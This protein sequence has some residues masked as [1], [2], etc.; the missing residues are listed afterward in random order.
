MN[1]EAEGW[2]KRKKRGR[3]AAAALLAGG[4]AFWG[5]PGFAAERTEVKP[6]LPAFQPK[7]VPVKW[8]DIPAKG[9][10]LFYPGQSSWD[11]LVNPQKGFTHPGAPV[12]QAGVACRTCHVKGGAGPDE[13]ALGKKLVPKGPA[14]DKPIAGKRPTVDLAVRAAYDSQNMYFWLQWESEE[15]GA[16]HDVMRFDGKKWV[17]Y[18]GYKP[19]KSPG[20]YEDRLTLNIGYK[21]GSPGYV[22]AD[23]GVSPG[24]Q[25]AGCFI[26]C[27]NSMRD[28]PYD[29]LKNK[30][31]VQAVFPKESDIRKYLLTTRKPAQ[32]G[33]PKAL[34]GA[35]EAEGRWSLLK[36]KEE[37]AGMRK[38]GQF[39]DMWMWRGARSG[40]IG[41]ADDIWVF[42]YRN[43]DK[44]K[45][46]WQRQQPKDLNATPPKGF[47]FNPQVVPSGRLGGGKH[48]IQGGS[49]PVEVLKRQETIP[50]I[51]TLAK[52]AVPYDPKAY[53]PK[54]G[55]LLFQRVLRPPDESRGDIQAYGVYLRKPG[56]KMGKWTLILKRKLDTG[57]PEDDVILKDG[58]I[59][60]IGF[61]VHDDHVTTRRHHVSFEYT[62]GMGT[63]ADIEAKKIR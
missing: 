52:G 41:Y 4:V 50:F 8:D 30:K 58:E 45:G 19:D 40:H 38:K 57:H 18:G 37:L 28:M 15:P 39:L 51:T 36:G 33:D 63:K 17:G 47:M 46:P 60:P 34:Q 3:A 61:A 9:I 11:R 35:T 6:E 31:G 12:I 56:E 43:S 59:Y 49:N 20:L 13:E 42:D 32:A 14:E 1:R 53:Q 25:S 62:L 21:Q 54:E 23:G 27:H 7:D 10:R 29:A 24:F 22:T 44:G 48:A 16:Y 26:T 2:L 55:D 5:A